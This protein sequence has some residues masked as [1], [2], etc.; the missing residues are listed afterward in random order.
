LGVRVP[1]RLPTYFDWEI[2][3][4]TKDNRA[5]LNICYALLA[6]LSSY[7]ANQALLLVG[8]RFGWVERYD[9]WYPSVSLLL[10]LVI[11]CSF[12]F[13]LNFSK[14]R[15]EYYLNTVEE[16]SKVHWPT[17]MD[18]KRMTLVVVVVVGIFAVILSVFDIVWTKSLQLLLPS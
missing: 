11:G 1:P 2:S 16:V 5:W 12:V 4:V 18:V 14:E 10:S 7:V 8:S 17:F 13:W 6:V 15:S 9:E 3:K